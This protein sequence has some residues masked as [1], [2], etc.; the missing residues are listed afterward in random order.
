MNIVLR[1]I[2]LSQPE[3]L[4]LYKKTFKDTASLAF[5][6]DNIFGTFKIY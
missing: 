1:P 3:L 5:Y 2:P 6:M 4:L